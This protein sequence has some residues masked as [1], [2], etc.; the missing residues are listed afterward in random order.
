MFCKDVDVVVPLEESVRYAPLLN[1][2]VQ[3]FL[4]V[5]FWERSVSWDGSG[6][7]EDIHDIANVIAD[8]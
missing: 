1:R 2:C 4:D 8:T 6:N 7:E 3:A 5:Y